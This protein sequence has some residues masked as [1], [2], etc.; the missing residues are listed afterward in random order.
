MN[1]HKIRESSKNH[2]L[3]PNTKKERELTRNYGQQNKEELQSY[4]RQPLNANL[5]DQQI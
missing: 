1:T 4:H 2:T 3:V 5:K